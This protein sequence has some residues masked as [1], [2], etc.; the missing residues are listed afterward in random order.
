MA[1]RGRRQGGA[2]DADHPA[3]GHA[4]QDQ[5]ARRRRRSPTALKWRAS[6]PTYLREQGTGKN[7]KGKSKIIKL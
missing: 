1:A 7:I 3:G 6:L 2:D 4:Q 5:G